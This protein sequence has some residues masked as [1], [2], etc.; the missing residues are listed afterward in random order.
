MHGRFSYPLGLLHH[1]NLA[2]KLSYNIMVVYQLLKSKKFTAKKEMP[3]V[4]LAISVKK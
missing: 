3:L 4:S 2:T 1:L